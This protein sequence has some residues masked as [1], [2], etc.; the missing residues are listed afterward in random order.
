[1]KKNIFS[2]TFIIILFI[3]III[4]AI[5]IRM[6]QFFRGTSDLRA[7]SQTEWTSS[8]GVQEPKSQEGIIKE[9]S[10]LNVGSVHA[11]G[12]IIMKQE[13]SQNIDIYVKADLPDIISNSVYLLWLYGK[14]LEEWKKLGALEKDILGYYVLKRTLDPKDLDYD[15]MRVTLNHRS[16]SSTP[17]T[18]ILKRNLYK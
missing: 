18:V 4:T 11:T 8:E 17:G 9:F 7:K 2:D 5:S 14:D 16:A 1:M 12:T 13:G 3:V 6:I 10:L 15:E